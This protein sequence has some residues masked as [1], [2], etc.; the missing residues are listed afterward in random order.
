[1]T[2]EGVALLPDPFQIFK[3]LPVTGTLIKFVS[4]AESQLVIN[5]EKLFR[6]LQSEV[7]PKWYQFG[8]AVGIKEEVLEELKSQKTFSVDEYLHKVLDYWLRT[9]QPTWTVITEALKRINLPH[10]AHDI[11]AKTNKGN[12]NPLYIII[13]ILY[14]NYSAFVSMHVY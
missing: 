8:M 1:M 3:H 13:V 9:T 10:L 11:E 7:A 4:Y 12:H 14:V 6:L 2:F 5:R